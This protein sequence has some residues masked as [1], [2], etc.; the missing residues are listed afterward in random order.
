MLMKYKFTIPGFIIFLLFL[1]QLTGIL[2]G[3]FTDSKFFCWAPFD[4][5]SIY[6]V[7]ADVDGKKLSPEEIGSRYKI[8]HSGRQNRSIHNIISIVRQY[9][10]TYGTDERAEVEIIYLINGHKQGS[11]TWPDDEYHYEN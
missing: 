5:I 10:A 2:A 7:H 1:L 4:E 11:W 8:R 6:T 3:R 9:E